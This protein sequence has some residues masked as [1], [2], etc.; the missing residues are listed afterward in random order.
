[1]R[2][3]PSGRPRK[4]STTQ[5]ESGGVTAARDPPP[6]AASAGGKRRRDAGS[7]A[8]LGRSSEGSGERVGLVRSAAAGLT[9]PSRRLPPSTPAGPPSPSLRPSRPRP[10]SGASGDAPRK[11]TPHARGCVGNDDG[12]SAGWPRKEKGSRR[13][14]AGEMPR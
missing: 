10:V 9:R 2:A 12:S 4:S 5:S 7:S 1:M 11:H 14:R 8:A 6:R 3:T 13:A